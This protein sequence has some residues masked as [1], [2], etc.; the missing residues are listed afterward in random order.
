MGNAS[1]SSVAL[2]KDL[3][4]SPR[5]AGYSALQITLHW[6]IAALV[7]FQILAH[8]GMEAAWDSFRKHTPL[9][10]EDAVFS[11]LHIY[12]GIVIFV[13]ALIWIWLRLKR[14]APALPE[15]EHPLLKFL[16]RA[17][18]FVLYL[19]IIGMPIL[20]AAGWYLNIPTLVHL[21]SS[22]RLLLVPLVIFHAAAAFVQHF[23]MK[24]DVLRRM[25]VVRN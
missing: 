17:T 14:G 8:D 22:G 7:I 23:W 20:G 16:A 11:D 10:P 24:S 3:T 5:P 21:H 25:I 4:M 1:L 18:H 9:S 2:N 6:A 19:L 15:G 13:L 12:A